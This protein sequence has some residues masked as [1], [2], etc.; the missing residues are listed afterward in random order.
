MKKTFFCLFVSLFL[1]SCSGKKKM[2]MDELSVYDSISVSIDYPILPQ[3]VRLVPYCKDASIYAT[4]YNHYNHSIDFVN[5]SGGDNFIITLQKEGPD[6]V[7]PVQLFCFL[8]DKIVCRDGSG[9]LTLAMD[10]SVMNRLPRKDLEMPAE[11]YSLGVKGLYNYRYL[12]SFDNKVLIPLSPITRG[13][14]IHIGKMYDV[15]HDSSEFLPPCYPPEVVDNIQYLESLSVP[16]INM[17]GTDKIVYNFPFSSQVYLYDWK[18][19]KMKVLDVQSGTIDN[20]LDFEEWKDMG[21]VDRAVKEFYMSRF[22]RVYYS[23]LLGKYYRVHYGTQEKGSGKLR[24]MYL[25]VF[26]ESGSYTKE[27]LLPLQFSE[28]YFF[29]DNNL[30]FACRNSNDD[31]F[32]I[33]R[34]SLETL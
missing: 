34:I 29:L 11:Q 32:N 33:A 6:A 28:Q 24:N 10:G 21:E 26:D 13:D 7:L 19:L 16:D 9:I 23:P 3:Y 5:L 22:G 27:Y 2:E 15:L 20:E 25:M 31:F 14:S 18:K 12:N 17:Y 1:F 8:G 30:Y 4:G